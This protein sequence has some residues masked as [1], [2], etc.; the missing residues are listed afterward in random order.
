MFARIFQGFKKALLFAL[1]GVFFAINIQ[2]EEIKVLG[3]A[4]LKYVL[5][6]IKNDFL[7]D[8]KSDKIEITYLS[9][10]KAYAQIKNGLPAHL[11]VAADVSYPA[12]LYEE[13]LTPEKEVIYARGKLVL[14]SNNADFKITDLK[15]ILNPKIT[16]IALP[17]PKVVPFGRAA[18]EV[19]ESTKLL[20]RIKD[21]FVVGESIGAAT[22]YVESKN[23]EVGFSALSMLGEGGIHTDTMSY[24]SIDEKLHKPI[25]QALVLLKEGANSKLARDF[26]D[27]ILSKKAKEKFIKFGYS[28]E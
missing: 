3:A 28:V 21:K 27:Y 5:D 18:I 24:V 20:D 17:N 16:H 15:D 9:S 10:G 7:K 11:F 6:E 12:K 8:R 4:S 13:K 2:A 1:C 22:T 26:R 25:D 19:L 23:A 14:W